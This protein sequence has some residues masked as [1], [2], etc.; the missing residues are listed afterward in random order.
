MK[1][2]WLILSIILLTSIFCSAIVYVHYNFKNEV[3]EEDFF[4]GVSFGGNTTSQAKLLIDKVKGYTNLFI[5]NSWETSKNE[6]TLNEICEYAVDAKM[7]FMVF[8]IT[9]HILAIHGISHGLTLQRK[10]G[11]TNSW[12]FTSTMSLVE[13]KL[14]QDD[15]M[16]R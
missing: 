10:G 16:K 12:A 3:S 7:N 8:L 9:F 11:K 15:G 6:T 14:T 1:L 5:I 13:D 2:T 4:F